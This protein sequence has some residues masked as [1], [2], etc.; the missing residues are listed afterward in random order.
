MRP[1]WPSKCY[2]AQCH[3]FLFCMLCSRATAR[4]NSSGTF[5]CKPRTAQ[6]LAVLQRIACKCGPSVFSKH[7]RR[8]RL[9]SSA[10]CTCGTG[11]VPASR[12]FCRLC[13][14][15]SSRHARRI[16]PLLF[17]SCICGIRARPVSRRLCKFCELNSSTHTSR[18]PTPPLPLCTCCMAGRRRSLS[19]RDAASKN[20]AAGNETT[21]VLSNTSTWSIGTA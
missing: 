9:S 14:S 3:C 21:P 8:T 17:A 2:S 12:R 5:L 19:T 20:A 13:P 18:I 7:S 10:C 11:A 1:Q 16:Q 15:V 4:T 6:G